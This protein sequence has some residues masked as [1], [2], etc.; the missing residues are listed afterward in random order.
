MKNETDPNKLYII[1]KGIY[2]R[3]QFILDIDK[4]FRFQNFMSDFREIV[5]FRPFFEVR[6]DFRLL[7]FRQVGYHFE[8]HDLEKQNKWLV[9]KIF[10]YRKNM[11][12]NRFREIHK[13]SLKIAKFEYFLRNKLYICNLQITC[14]KMKYV[15]VL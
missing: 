15:Y 9:T 3:V 1:G 6:K 2:R 14:F 8:E 4:I 11:S 10:K 13:S 5:K 12:N 7:E